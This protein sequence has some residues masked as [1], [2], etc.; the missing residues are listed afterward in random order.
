M[1]KFVITL[2]IDVDV[3]DGA[4]LSKMPKLLDKTIKEVVEGMGGGSKAKVTSLRTKEV[5]RWKVVNKN[6]FDYGRIGILVSA[7]HEAYLLEFDDGS[8]IQFKESEIKFI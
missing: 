5:K 7:R 6:S 2:E 1:A 8:V 4:V 3:D